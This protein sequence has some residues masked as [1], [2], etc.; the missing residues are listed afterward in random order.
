[1]SVKTQNSRIIFG[2]KVK[3]LRVEHN[4]LSK[5]LAEQTGMSVSYLNE[6]E[7]GKKY[8]KPDKIQA[9]ADTF[10]V[11]FEE[12]SSLELKR[13][14][15]PVGDLLH[16]NFLNELPLDLF[17]IEL[18]KV[19]EI[20]AN[21][22]LRVGAFI[23][24]LVELA[25]NYALREENFYFGALRSYI[26]LHNNYFEDIETAAAEFALEHQLSQQSLVP[27]ESLENLLKQEYGYRIVKDGLS[28]YPELADLR[29]LLLPQK[30]KLLLNGGLTDVQIAFQYGKEI[31]FKVLKL[32]DRVHTSSLLRLES[33]EQVLSHYKA[34]YFSSALLINRTSFVKDL[35]IFFQKKKW[36]G[37]AFVSLLHKYQSSPEM[38]YQ[39]LTNVIPQ[40]FG[41]EKIFFFRIV[42]LTQQDKFEIQKEM[43][44]NRQHQPHGNGLHEHYCRRWLSVSLLKDL[45][46]IQRS[47]KYVGTIV[48]AQRSRYFGSDDE[49]LCITLARP[50]APAA[51][52]N[53]SVTIGLLINQ[54]SSSRIQ[55]L[56]DPAISKTEVN[57]TCERCAIEN[58]SERAVPAV[59]I[60]KR[61]AR[62]QIQEALKELVK[63]H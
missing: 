11:S 43:H 12:L 57:N 28:A 34:S 17:G 47:G 54:E 42:H 49:Y 45:F 18:S 20:I 51:G 1:M 9:L 19:V 63:N 36:D 24:T 39:R 14:L 62:K 61:K 41:L 40:F 53:I 13:S 30:K 29:T 23:S 31:G 38:L 58:C 26:E 16:S 4:L 27:I 3:Q 32:K 60:E 46:H 48:G 25:R 55:F 8:P 2:L 33:F 7:K 37:E 59:V 5:E 10:N 50:D 6:I 44:L 21:S 22:P 56:N 52:R 15:A 35:Q